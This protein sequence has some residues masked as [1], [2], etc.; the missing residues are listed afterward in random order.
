MIPL[1][2]F[3]TPRG[4]AIGGAALLLVFGGVQTLRLGHAKGDLSEARQALVTEKAGAKA[5]KASL[6]LSEDK[7]AVEYSLAVNDAGAAEDACAARVATAHRSATK[8][9]SIVEKPH[10]VD[11]A[12]GCVARAIVGA[13]ELR[14]AL[15]PAR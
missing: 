7:R 2:S 12:T 11:P 4:W 3:L 9:R 14:D 13:G 1:L 15:Q 10:A 6:K 8:I 5:L